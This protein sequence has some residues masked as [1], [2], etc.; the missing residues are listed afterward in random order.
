[1][2]LS[3]LVPGAGARLPTSLSRGPCCD[4]NQSRTSS[5]RGDECAP[6]GW[7]I[8]LAFSDRDLIYYALERTWALPGLFLEVE[9]LGQVQVPGDGGG[10]FYFSSFIP[11]GG[12]Q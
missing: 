7:F 6:L 4:H 11:L 2:L 1:M 12:L 3:F 5:E 9:L 10:D 8:Q